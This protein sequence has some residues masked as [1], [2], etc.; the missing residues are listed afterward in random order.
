VKMQQRP[1]TSVAGRI[2]KF[3]SRQTFRILAH[4]TTGKELYT[5][6]AIR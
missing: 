4:K 2:K 6:R 1:A 3:T 5:S